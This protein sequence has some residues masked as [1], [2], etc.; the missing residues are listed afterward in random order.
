MAYYEQRDRAREEKRLR[1]Q[2]EARQAEEAAERQ[3][4]REEEAEKERLRKLEIAQQR[5]KSRGYSNY[6]SGEAKG[7]LFV[8]AVYAACIRTAFV[9]LSDRALVR[10]FVCVPACTNI[11]F[12]LCLSLWART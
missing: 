3:R 10:A 2:E 8:A 9:R 6:F 5:A 4:L 11:A 7:H 1:E 12:C